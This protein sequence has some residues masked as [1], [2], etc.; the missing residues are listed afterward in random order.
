MN[1]C[2]GLHGKECDKVAEQYSL[3]CKE[4]DIEHRKQAE[5]AHEATQNS[6]SDAF[7]RKTCDTCLHYGKPVI[8][9][10]CCACTGYTMWEDI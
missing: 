6:H 9:A 10:P 4:H 7:S 2:I 8:D 5:K 1:I 3:L